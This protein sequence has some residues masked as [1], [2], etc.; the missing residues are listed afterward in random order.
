MDFGSG[1][2]F[3]RIAH[4]A[5]V[6]SLLVFFYAVGAV[7]TTCRGEKRVGGV[8]GEDLRQPRMQLRPLIAE[9][10]NRYIPVPGNVLFV[11]Q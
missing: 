9:K 4:I 2:V 6:L 7:A 11:W 5:R 8:T 10:D 3:I 1:W